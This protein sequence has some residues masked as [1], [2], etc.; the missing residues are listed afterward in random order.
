MQTPRTTKLAA[1][2]E[3]LYNDRSADLLFHG[4][5][6]IYFV[7][8]KAVQ[9]AKEYDVDKEQIEAAALTHDLNY[10]VKINSE[11]EAGKQ[12]RDLI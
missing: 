8:K 10:L 1:D 3:K 7:A 9:F 2:L 6:H 12:L 4:W 5:H 11:P